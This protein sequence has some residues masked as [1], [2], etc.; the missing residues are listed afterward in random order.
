MKK[1]HA[2]GR[3]MIFY[4]SAEIVSFYVIFLLLCSPLIL[5]FFKLAF[6]RIIRCRIDYLFQLKSMTTHCPYRKTVVTTIMPLNSF[7]NNIAL[8]T[9]KQLIDFC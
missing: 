4:F 6:F 8:T 2:S 1:P 7:L 9:Y 3:E 5:S